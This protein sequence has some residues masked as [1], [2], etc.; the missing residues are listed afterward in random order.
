ME[1]D[2]RALSRGSVKAGGGRW[3]GAG[4][5]GGPYQMQRAGLTGRDVPSCVLAE[6]FDQFED[7]WLW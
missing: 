3:T 6:G 1:W 7:L 5:V 4:Q 2:I